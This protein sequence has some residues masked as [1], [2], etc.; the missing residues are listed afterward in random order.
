M[1]PSLTSA[2]PEARRRRHAGR[3]TQPRRVPRRD[4]SHRRSRTSS[5]SCWCRPP[6]CE[7]LNERGVFDG[8]RGQAGDPRQRHHRH[9]GRAAA[10]ATQAASRPFRTACLSRVMYGATSRSRQASRHRSRPLLHH[11]QQRPRRRPAHAG[12]VPR[13]SRRAAAQRLQ[14]LPRSVRPE[15][16]RRHRPPSSCRTTSTTASCAASPASPAERPQFLKIVYN[17]PKALEELASYDPSLV[18]GVLGGG[19]GTTRD[20]LRAAGPGRA[21][22]RPGRAVRPQDQPRRRSPLAMVAFMRQVADGSI[23]PAEA[24]RAYHGELQKLGIK[25][26]RDRSDER[27]CHHRGGAQGRLRHRDG[28]RASR[29]RHRRH[30]VRRPQQADRFLAGR[31]CGGRD[32]AVD[33]RGGGSA[34]NLAIDIK[35]LDPAMPVETIGLVGDDEDGRFL[36][37]KPTRTASPAPAAVTGGAADA[38]HR[39]LRLAALRP[40]HAHLRAG[41]QRAPDA[42]PFRPR[43]HDRPHPPSGPARRASAAWTGHGQATPTAGSRCCKPAKAAGLATNLELASIAPEQS[44]RS[45]ALPARSGL[46]GRQRQRDRRHRRPV[47]RP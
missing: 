26:L 17:G 9:L 24:V 28:W 22:R 13:V 11:L 46:S 29:H 34:C 27:Y 2:R 25:P 12:S 43:G 19:A 10:A 32:P 36:L 6:T 31:G 38:I 40:P 41:R 23:A 8:Q 14:V 5:T 45:P 1:G 44:G 18:I 42:G 20:M 3:A 30:L 7:L 37:A 15:R 21:L 16:R 47:H 4:R 39:C 33:A 35:K